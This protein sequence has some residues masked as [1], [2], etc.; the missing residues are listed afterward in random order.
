M[1]GRK[2]EIERQAP[3]REAREEGEGGAGG[4]GEAV[5]VVVAEYREGC[6]EGVEGEE[7]A[8]E[9]EGVGGEEPGGCEAGGWVERGGDAEVGVE[10]L[11]FSFFVWL[12]MWA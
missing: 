10:G 9:R 8:E 1:Q 12:C 3:V 11:H 5:R 2:E 6:C 7:E 4:G